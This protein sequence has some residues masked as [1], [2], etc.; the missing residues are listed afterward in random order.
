MA[1]Q[2][3]NADNQQG[4]ED[5]L[6]MDDVEKLYL[7]KPWSCRDIDMMKRALYCEARKCFKKIL[8]E[9]KFK[10][11]SYEA[12]TSVFHK[13]IVYDLP[14]LKVMVEYG[15]ENVTQRHLTNG[16]T[17]LHTATDRISCQYSRPRLEHLSQTIEYLI[18]IGASASATVSKTHEDHTHE[19]YTHEDHTPLD[20]VSIKIPH[21]LRVESNNDCIQKLLP[22]IEKLID[23]MKEEKKGLPISL[24]T[25]LLLQDNFSYLLHNIG[26]LDLCVK[27]LEKLLKAGVNLRGNH[28]PRFSGF[29]PN[30]RFENFFER[31][32]ADDLLRP[33]KMHDLVNNFGR[34][35]KIFQYIMKFHMLLLVYGLEPD[36]KWSLFLDM[37]LHYQPTALVPLVPRVLSIMDQELQYR[38]QKTDRL[39][40]AEKLGI[41]YTQ[42]VAIPM[43]C[44]S[45]KELCRRAMYK[46]IRDGRMAA[47]VGHLEIPN[48]LKDFLLFQD[49]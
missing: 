23:A 30:T 7:H 15:Y 29:N 24:L 31:R 5:A 20:Y 26:N 46:Y 42:S 14:S 41:D 38:I 40:L 11:W 27:I 35:G 32:Y 44:H 28:Q 4:I 18:S 37:I 33:K 45:L 9:K 39:R 21:M 47:H 19:D 10:E 13:S 12:L 25:V 49:N 3:V 6:K 34:D 1:L 43:K 48:E 8:T 22:G 17:P 2:R 16:N 36:M